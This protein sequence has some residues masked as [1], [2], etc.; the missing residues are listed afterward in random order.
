MLEVEVP[1]VSKLGRCSKPRGHIE[2]SVRLSAGHGR[3]DD[4]G[5]GRAYVD[6]QGVV[7]RGV[8]LHS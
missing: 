2:N 5:P 7:D 6:L 4:W 3:T 8:P 1:C